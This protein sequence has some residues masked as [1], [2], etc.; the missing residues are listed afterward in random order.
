MPRSS[1]FRRE[2]EGG[3][4]AAK[5]TGQTWG[6]DAREASAVDPYKFLVA[7]RV[8]AC[9]LMLPLLALAADFSGI[10]LAWISSALSERMSLSPICGER[11][12]KHAVQRLRPAYAQKPPA[13]GFVIGTVSCLQ[14]MR[15]RG[16]TEGVGQAATSSVVVSWWLWPTLCSWGLILTLLGVK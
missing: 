15:T 1:R 8:L 12:Q 6:H 9:V 11:L 13:L 14:G 2:T 4:S 7:T 16:G 10:L 3:S 5:T